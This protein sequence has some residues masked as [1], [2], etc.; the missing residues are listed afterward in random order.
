MDLVPHDSDDDAS[1]LDIAINEDLTD[2]ENYHS[3]HEED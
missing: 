3:I 2:D 1:Q